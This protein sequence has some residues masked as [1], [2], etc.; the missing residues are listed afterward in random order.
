MDNGTQG[1]PDRVRPAQ[2]QITYDVEVDA[3]NANAQVSAVLPYILAASRF[4][5]YLKVICRDKIGSLQTARTVESYLN[6]WIDGSMQ[7]IDDAG[8]DITAKYPLS[9]ARVDV[10]E[11]T[12]KPGVF[13]AVAVLRP[14]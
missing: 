13:E 7:E 1:R 9:E 6:R 10:N 4:A 2:V 11:V 5:H 14:H 12:G 3:A 8:H